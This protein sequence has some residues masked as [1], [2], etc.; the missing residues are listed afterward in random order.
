MAEPTEGRAWIV[1]FLAIVDFCCVLQAAERYDRGQALVGT[2]WLVAGVTFSV[3]GYKWPALKKRV[4]GINWAG[5]KRRITVAF[6]SALGL[7]LA[8]AFLTA[9]ACYRELFERGQHSAQ[10]PVAGPPSNNKP[11]E[12]QVSQSQSPAPSSQKKPTSGPIPITSTAVPQLSRVDWHDIHNWRKYLHA[13]MTKTQVRQLFG[14]PER[15]SV[16][17]TME[18]WE[19]GSGEIDID[20]EDKPGG[21][22]WLWS[23]PH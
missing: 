22:L 14:E 3:A 12:S 16:V 5:W 13:G 1:V 18:F 8:F 21:S 10:Q 7:S 9:R 15:M 6:Y 20:V 11:M 23:E 17:G 4:A 19:Y 2:Y